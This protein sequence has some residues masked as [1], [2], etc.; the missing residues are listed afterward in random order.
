MDMV[1]RT[2]DRMADGG[3]FDQVG[4]GVHRYSTDGRWLVPHFEV[5]GK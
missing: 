5:G 1:R 3:I 4:G 2:L